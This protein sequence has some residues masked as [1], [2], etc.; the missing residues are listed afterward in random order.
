MPMDVLGDHAGF[1]LRGSAV[2]AA[3]EQLLM[4]IAKLEAEKGGEKTGKR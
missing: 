2:Q 4:D 3:A 1:L